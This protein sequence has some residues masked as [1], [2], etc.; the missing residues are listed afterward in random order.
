M[1]GRFKRDDSAAAGQEPR[2][3]NDRGTSPQHPPY[4]GPAAAGDGGDHA[5]RTPGGPGGAGRAAG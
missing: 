5:A 3:G 2:G 1:Q 4:P